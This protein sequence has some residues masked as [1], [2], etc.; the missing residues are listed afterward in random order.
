MR[1]RVCSFHILMVTAATNSLGCLRQTRLGAA[2]CQPPSSLA[3]CTA[4]FPEF[5]SSAMIRAWFCGPRPS[6]RSACTA[7]ML[8]PIG[9]QSAA[10]A[11]CLGARHLICL[12]VRVRARHAS[13]ASTSCVTG[14]AA[15]TRGTSSRHPLCSSIRASAAREMPRRRSRDTMKSSW[16]RG[17]N[18]PSSSS[19]SSSVPTTSP[20][21]AFQRNGWTMR[22]H[23]RVKRPTLLVGGRTLHFCVR[24][25]YRAL[26]SRCSCCD[27]AI[28]RSRLLSLG[29]LLRTLL[30]IEPS[31]NIRETGDHTA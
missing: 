26:H 25:G 12:R 15:S 17:T 18:R 1:T 28:G 5:P 21:A 16:R 24:M 29:S 9:C 6:L 23:A 19:F 20:T 22:L 10:I 31:P 4:P 8:Q 11:R 2:S 30:K 7:T 3:S 27:V 14:E 13:V